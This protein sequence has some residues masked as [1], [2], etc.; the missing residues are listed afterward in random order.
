MIT[1]NIQSFVLIMFVTYRNAGPKVTPAPSFFYQRQSF[2]SISYKADWRPGAEINLKKSKQT[3]TKTKAKT[4][5][6][7]TKL[8]G[9]H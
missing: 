9:M 4:K 1:N 2:T 3:K 7:N 6:H 8:Q 5:N